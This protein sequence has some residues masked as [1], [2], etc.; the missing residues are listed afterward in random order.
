MKSS[1]ERRYLLSLAR[2]LIENG[3]TVEDTAAHVGRSVRWVRRHCLPPPPPN[4]RSKPPAGRL[5]PAP[6]GYR[7]KPS[8]ELPQIK[9]GADLADA[10]AWWRG[11]NA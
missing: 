10:L 6:R 5:K 3:E 4:K 11:A 1:K 9:S 7:P 8:C 2:L